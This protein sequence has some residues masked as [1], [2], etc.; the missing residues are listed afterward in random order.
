YPLLKKNIKHVENYPDFYD[1][2]RGIGW[3]RAGGETHSLGIKEYLCVDGI[4]NV[5]KILD[6]IENEKLKDIRYVECLACINGCVG[7]PL[8]VENS[9]VARNRIRRLAEQYPQKKELHLN[10]NIEEFLFTQKIRPKDI[11]KLDDDMVV[12]IEKMGKI[13]NIYE[14][15][16]KLDCGACGSPTCRSLAEDIVLGY[17]NLDDCIVLFRDKVKYLLAQNQEDAENSPE[18]DTAQEA[19]SENKNTA[20]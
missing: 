14:Q 17:S 8:T 3:A 19:D 10:Q 18:Q 1:S 12:A 9:F 15:L 7:G 13:D 11:G 4:E 20:E 16:P 6:E 5:I 2:G